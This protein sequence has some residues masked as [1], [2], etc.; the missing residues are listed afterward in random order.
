VTD[1]DGAVGALVVT[2][3]EQAFV[4]EGARAR[5]SAFKVPTVWAVVTDADAVPLLASGKVDKTALQALLRNGA[6]NR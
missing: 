3:E 5:L 1:V 6:M 4:V 2:G